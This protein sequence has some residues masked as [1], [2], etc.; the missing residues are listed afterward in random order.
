MAKTFH[1]KLFHTYSNWFPTALF[2]CVPT[3]MITGQD[4]HLGNSFE[5]KQNERLMKPH[6][7]STKKIGLTAT[8]DMGLQRKDGTKLESQRLKNGYKMRDCGLRLGRV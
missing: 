8:K 3:R 6:Y 2:E 7:P 4:R 5:A 1:Q